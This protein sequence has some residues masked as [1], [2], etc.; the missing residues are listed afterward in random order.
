MS[1]IADE[2]GCVRRALVLMMISDGDVDPDEL[3]TIREVYERITSVSVS[4]TEL[5]AEAE[6]M[7]AA[8]KRLGEC[9]ELGDG[10]DEPARLRV[11]DAVFE[12]AAAD[13]FVVDEEDHLLVRLAVDLGLSQATYRAA[14]EKLLAA[15]QLD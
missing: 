8:G 11:F 12:V 15:R 4:E 9:G 13:G 7:L 2:R 6:A 10:L 5:R 3:A 1:E 14:I